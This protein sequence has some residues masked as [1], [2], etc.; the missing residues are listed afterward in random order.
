[1]GSGPAGGGAEGR[2]GGAGAGPGWGRQSA[3]PLLQ[4]LR[5]FHVAWR[6]VA[7]VSPGCP[8]RPER[9]PF[10]S[11]AAMAGPGPGQ[12]D[13][14]EQY[15]FLFKLVLVGDA[16]VGK[17]CVVQRFKT[18]AFSERQG[19]TIGVDFT[20]KT[21]EVQGKRVKVGGP[22]WGRRAGGGLAFSD[23]G[24]A[25]ATTGTGG[26]PGTP[27]GALPQRGQG[28]V[29]SQTAA[30]APDCSEVLTN[31]FHFPLPFLL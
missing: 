27:E 8:Q 14:D 25:G 19:S 11:R 15:D 16:S 21:L 3:A 1:M 5:W 20:M 31:P 26:R 22:A 10:G 6:S 17:T 28:L 29:Q 23:C 12:G 13:P 2:R 4:V 18:G 30:S 9:R 7:S 24:A